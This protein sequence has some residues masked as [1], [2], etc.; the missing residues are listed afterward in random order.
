M[1]SAHRR[2]AATRL[3]PIIGL[4]LMLSACGGGSSSSSTGTSDSG[5]PP[6]PTPQA[7][8]SGNKAQGAL[9]SSSVSAYSQDLFSV[10]EFLG[11]NDAPSINEPAN[12]YDETDKGAGGGTVKITGFIDSNGDGWFEQ[13][14][15]NYVAEDA[16][17]VVQNGT[18]ILYQTEYG[19]VTTAFDHYTTTIAGKMLQYNGNIA[20][21]NNNPGTSSIANLSIS[22]GSQQILL[23]NFNFTFGSVTGSAVTGRLYDSSFGYVDVSTPEPL[24]LSLMGYVDSAGILQDRVYLNNDGDIKLMG[25]SG[26]SLQVQPLNGL[27]AY[28]GLDADGDGKI[29]AGTRFDMNAL[30]LE[31]VAPAG[32]SIS[33]LADLPSVDII[34]KPITV[35]G[36]FSYTPNGLISYSWSLVAAPFGSH[37]TISG[38]EPT[39]QFNPDVPGDYLVQLTASANGESAIDVVQISHM[40]SGSELTTPTTGDLI[41]NFAYAHVGETIT[42]DGR[43]SPADSIHI[44]QIVDYQKFWTLHSPD[45]STAT[46]VD[47]DQILTSFTPDVAGIYYAVCSQF[48]G[49]NAQAPQVMVIAVDQPVRFAPPAAMLQNVN[50]AGLNAA[51]FGGTGDGVAVMTAPSIVGPGVIQSWSP[52]SNGLFGTRSGVAFTGDELT[53]LLAVDLNGDG[54]SDFV[55]STNQNVSD[56]PLYFRESGSSG[57]ILSSVDLDPNCSH[58][59]AT[60]LLRGATIGGHPA[61]VVEDNVYGS[62]GTPSFATFLADASGN[63]QAPVVTTVNGSASHRQIL[64]FQLVDVDGDGEP[65]LIATLLETTTSTMSVVQVYHGN[66]DGSFTYLASYSLSSNGASE[67]IA[68]A[69]FNGDGKPDIAVN[70]GSVLDIFYGDGAGNFSTS[71]ETRSISCSGP[72]LQALDLNGDGQPDLVLGQAVCGTP[73]DD[74]A[75]Q[76]MFLS[77]ASTSSGGT[78]SLGSEQ[79]Y[80][81]VDANPTLSSTYVTLGGEEIVHGDFTGDGLQDLMFNWPD[82]GNVILMPQLPAITSATITS[83]SPLSERA[84]DLAAARV[85]AAH[86]WVKGIAGMHLSKPRL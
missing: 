73:Y 22:N 20:V 72:S 86:A 4:A 38:N 52:A 44:P 66:G 36:R 17:G 35:D 71:P 33:A 79:L 63:M 62:S 8:Y 68:V 9:A 78:S 75:V 80:P 51:D 26:S 13:S 41:Q 70:A 83:I 43:A 54:V 58:L 14:F 15:D 69:D 7:S 11:F 65:D 46:I 37:V 56:C 27:F 47:P 85:L 31:S 39:V 48:E 59:G 28:L 60:G 24:T 34:G 5:P 74:V 61:V 30:E 77:A 55:T 1:P 49:T 40:A 23:S 2:D 29:E 67:A 64:D 19:H 25:V 57:Y 76:G 53:N 84:V 81:M 82:D 42:L 21:Q 3:L 12:T 50:L 16:P 18:M 45:G 32:S 6:P 10:M